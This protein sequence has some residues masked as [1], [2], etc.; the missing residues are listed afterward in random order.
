MYF[1]TPVFANYIT[2]KWTKKSSYALGQNQGELEKNRSLV[3]DQNLD[4]GSHMELENYPALSQAP[5]MSVTDTT[6]D[7]MAASLDQIGVSKRL[8]FKR[9]KE[10]NERW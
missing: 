6:W 7:L 4:P 10:E 8:Y 2:E 9:N 3:K 1:T 5:N